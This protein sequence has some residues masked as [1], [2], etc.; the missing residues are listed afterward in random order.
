M[1]SYI[2]RHILIA[3]NNPVIYFLTNVYWQLLYSFGTGDVWDSYFYNNAKAVGQQLYPTGLYKYFD[4]SS[5]GGLFSFFFYWMYVALCDL[6][7]P[8]TLFVPFDIWMALVFDGLKWKGMEKYFIWYF[9]WA[10]GLNTLL[11]EFMHIP[12]EDGWTILNS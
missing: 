2:D 5:I 1:L 3:L 4:M 6:F 10:L 12:M 9:P 7:S 8:L 11:G